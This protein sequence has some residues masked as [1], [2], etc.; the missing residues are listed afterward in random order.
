MRLATVVFIV[1]VIVGMIPPFY[2]FGIYPTKN[3][4]ELCD[5]LYIAEQRFKI[6]PQDDSCCVADGIQKTLANQDWKFKRDG[7]D[8]FLNSYVK[9]N[10][11]SM[12]FELGAFDGT[13]SKKFYDLFRPRMFLVEP[14]A[15][16]FN[17]MQARFAGKD[18]VT[19]LNAGIGTEDGS[20]YLFDNGYGSYVTTNPVNAVPIQLVSWQTIFDRVGTVDLAYVNCEGCEYI[21][22][23]YLTEQHMRRIK[24]FY[25]QFHKQY[26]DDA[27]VQ[28]CVMRR[29]LRNTHRLVYQ[30]TWVWE[31][32]IL[33]S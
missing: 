10:S 25:I 11:S 22:L 2:L 32:W 30:V 27:P 28:R 33:D 8:T 26:Q 14:S 6:Y 18:G 12:Y 15:R 20:A 23:G 31:I 29:K 4:S 16:Y 21:V 13:T 17:T 7:Y 3:P 9:L 19:L 5:A 1:I 24:T